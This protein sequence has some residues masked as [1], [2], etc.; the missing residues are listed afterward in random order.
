MQFLMYVAMLCVF[1][2][3]I[4][5]YIVLHISAYYLLYTQKVVFCMQFVR[6]HVQ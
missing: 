3:Y 4:V 2:Y 5:L 6:V 1:L